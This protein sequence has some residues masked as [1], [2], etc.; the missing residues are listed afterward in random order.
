MSAGTKK[1]RFGSPLDQSVINETLRQGLADTERVSFADV[2]LTDIDPDPDN[3]RHLGFSAQSLKALNP[4]DLSPLEARRFNR[5]VQMSQTIRG[6]GQV[7]EPIIV[8]RHGSRYQLAIGERRFLASILAD[9]ATIPAKILHVRPKQLRLLQLVENFQREELTTYEVAKN[10]QS[11][12]DEWSEVHG[13]QPSVEI[14]GQAAG[15]EKSRVYTYLA[16]LRGPEDVLEAL[17]SGALQNLEKAYEIGKI[18]DPDERGRELRRYL[19][20]RDDPDA[21]PD[22]PAADQPAGSV[23]GRSSAYRVRFGAVRNP[24]IPRIIMARVL[25]DDYTTGIDWDDHKAVQAAW[26]N[27]IRELE[28]RFKDD[29]DYLPDASDAT[30]GDEPGGA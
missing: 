10:I 27:F 12:I 30:G 20:G 15:L 2:P 29:A 22:P 6:E 16:V 7:I 28:S 23:P 21:P 1:K 18:E 8:Y 4:D 19:K 17:K 3:P 13:D 24:A 5:L 11:V 26:K 14:I 25:G 9:K